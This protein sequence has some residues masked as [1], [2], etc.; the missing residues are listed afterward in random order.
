[1]ALMICTSLR[2]FSQT[3]AGSYECRITLAQPLSVAQISGFISKLSF[4]N[5]RLLNNKTTLV[6]DNGF[7]IILLS[8]NDANSAGLIK[9]ISTYAENFPRDF[10]L[11]IFHMTDNGNVGAGYSNYDK[12][13][14]GTQH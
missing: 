2:I 12:K 10:K 3:P 6:F 4:E 8:A 5:Y 13:Y 1:M 9:D 14:A 7:D 11:P